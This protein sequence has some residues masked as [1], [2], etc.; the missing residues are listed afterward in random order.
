MKWTNLYVSLLAVSRRGYC[1]N[2]NFKYFIV[3]ATAQKLKAQSSKLKV[4]GKYYFRDLS[5]KINKAKNSEN[6]SKTNT[7]AFINNSTISKKS[8]QK[9][10]IIYRNSS[11]SI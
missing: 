11:A 10:Q 1:L 5:K 8:H 3:N 2:G 4:S 6:E 7:S 9:D